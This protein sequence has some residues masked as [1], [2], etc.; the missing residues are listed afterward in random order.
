MYFCL[1]LVL[2]HIRLSHFLPFFHPMLEQQFESKLL[3]L[4]SSLLLIYLRRQGRMVQ[5]HQSLAPALESSSW[6]Q[7]SVRPSPGFHCGL[8]SKLAGE[9]QVSLSLLPI[10]L[11]YK[12]IQF[13]KKKKQNVLVRVRILILS[14]MGMSP[15]SY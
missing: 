1:G 6:L 5:G 4:Q 10:C 2:W 12:E 7:S 14:L 8:R 3:C 9:R 13:Y 11:L 15:L